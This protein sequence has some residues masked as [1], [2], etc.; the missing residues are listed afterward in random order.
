MNN[1]NNHL[2][3]SC[4]RSSV[5]LRKICPILNVQEKASEQDHAAKDQVVLQKKL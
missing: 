3:W 2:S 1:Q 5:H 4:L